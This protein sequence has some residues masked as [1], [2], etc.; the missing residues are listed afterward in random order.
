MCVCALNIFPNGEPSTVLGELNPGWGGQMLWLLEL[1]LTQTDGFIFDKSVN[2]TKSQ[3]II[4]GIKLVIYDGMA[5][6]II[7]KK[8]VTSAKSMFILLYYRRNFQHNQG[9]PAHQRSNVALDSDPGYLDFGPNWSGILF[10]K[11]LHLFGL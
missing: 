6:N 2:P 5:F 1:A 4:C 7:V 8:K 3:F 10:Q 11:A 9:K